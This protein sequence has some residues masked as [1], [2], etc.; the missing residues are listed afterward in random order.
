[1]NERITPELREM[2]FNV[3]DQA[4]CD[5]GERRRDFGQHL[6]S[7]YL[8]DLIC[9]VAYPVK[10]PAQPKACD[11][12]PTG[13]RCTRANGHEGPCAAIARALPQGAPDA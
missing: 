5:C 7:C 13:W 2:I 6:S 3:I 8:F 9:E 1:M 11:V 12:P 10:E 4:P